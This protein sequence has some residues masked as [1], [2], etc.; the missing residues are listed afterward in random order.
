MSTL[1]PVV[2]HDAVREALGTAVARSE[3]PGSLLFHGPAGSGK[4]RL[5]LWLAQRLVCEHAAPIEPCGACHSCYLALRV[6]HPDIHWFFPLPRPKSAGSADRLGEVLEE[7]RGAEL[8]ARREQPWRPLEPAEL[9]GI[10]LAQVLTLRRL[11]MRHP[12][13]GTRK[14]FLIG[15]AEH[16][17]SQE[18]STE[19]ANALLKVLEE[20]PQDTVFILT[21]SDPDGLLPTIRSRLLPVRV[22]TIP[23]STI[24]RLLRETHGASADDARLAARLSQ[25]A[26]GR[27]LAYLPRAGEPGSLETLRQ[28][29]R[30]LLEATLAGE[31]AG[32]F[33]AALATPPAGARAT[34]GDLLDSLALWIRDLGAT[35]DGAPECV[36]NVDSIDFLLSLS[37]QLTAHGRAVPEAL[38]SIDLMRGLTR[39][40]INPQ[41]G[42]AVLLQE[43]RSAFVRPN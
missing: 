38:R 13:M 11:V 39:S 37:R 19:A 31:P 29:G 20:P 6:E 33:M 32:R 3:L 40:N 2:E 35:L 18:A 21:A 1:P 10:Y 43:I 12:A 14:I 24:A 22:Q 23:E 4:Q 5:G 41:L 36:V 42:L 16:L 25:G 15:D 17:V 9:M 34:L 8:T 27:A 30:E 7:A 28:R 26:I